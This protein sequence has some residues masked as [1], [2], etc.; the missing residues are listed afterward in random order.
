[1]RPLVLA[2]ALIALASVTYST[3]QNASQC[4]HLVYQ[5]LYLQQC[6][7]IHNVDGHHTKLLDPDSF[8]ALFLKDAVLPQLQNDPRTESVEVTRSQRS[9]L[10]T[11]GSATQTAGTE[12]ATSS[13][14]PLAATTDTP[15][16]AQESK[17]GK[18][19]SFEEWKRQ[20]V[21]QEGEDTNRRRKLTPPVRKSVSHQRQ[22]IDSI[23][24]AFGDDVGSMFDNSEDTPQQN[25]FHQ[26]Y[27]L[28][29]ATNQDPADLD[30]RPLKQSYLSSAPWNQQK[31]KQS[32]PPPPP[33][34][35]SPPPPSQQRQQNTPP[36]TDVPPRKTSAKSEK[37]SINPLKKLKELYN[38]AS[39]DCAATVLQANKGAKNPQAILY[40]S[41]DQYML[42][43]CSS[44]KF[45]IV[46]LCE[47]ILI[48]KFVLANYEFFSS[49]FKDFRVY[50]ADRYPPKEW[51]LLGQ[52]QARNTRD[53]QIFKVE[54]G[55]DWYQYIK[56]EFLSHYGNEYYCP[57]SLLRVHG[58][59]MMEYWTLYE[60]PK[61]T[62]EDEEEDDLLKGISPDP[63]VDET[64]FL[65]PAFS[66]VDIAT[67]L[68]TPSIPTV[69]DMLIAEREAKSVKLDNLVEHT[70]QHPESSSSLAPNES[71]DQS[72]LHNVVE[73]A[74][75]ATENPLQNNTTFNNN[76]ANVDESHLNLQTNSTDQDISLDTEPDPSKL[77]SS[78]N[79][80]SS[81]DGIEVDIS[82]PSPASS[83]Y[84]NVPD[85][86]SNDAKS[87]EERPNSQHHTISE[88]TSPSPT[89]EA[90]TV[91]VASDFNAQSTATTTKAP[92]GY[93]QGA[94][95]ES[96]YKTI[97]TRILNLEQNATLSQRYLDDQ[98]RML[99][100]VF[101][102]MEQRHHEQL[103]QLVGQLNSTASL[104]I[105]TMKRRY[106]RLYRMTARELEMTK[107]ETSKELQE[108]TAKLHIMADQ[109]VFEKRLSLIQ[110]ILLVSLFL[111]TAANKGTLSTLSPIVAAQAEERQ[112]RQSISH[113]QSSASQTDNA[114]ERPKLYHQPSKQVLKISKSSET[115]TPSK[116]SEIPEI[117]EAK[118]ELQITKSHME[119]IK[120]K[121]TRQS[122]AELLSKTAE[123]DPLRHERWDI[124][125]G[126]NNQRKADAPQIELKSDPYSEELKKTDVLPDHL[127]T[128]FLTDSPTMLSDV[129]PSPAL[130]H[131]VHSPAP[132]IDH[133]QLDGD[134]RLS[135]ASS[136]VDHL[137]LAYIHSPK[138]HSLRRERRKESST[139]DDDHPMVE[140]IQHIDNPPCSIDDQS[141]SQSPSDA[142]SVD[143]SLHNHE[144]DEAIVPTIDGK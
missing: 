24:G 41:K 38:Y 88:H 103:L 8:D 98:N 143:S 138:A 74:G 123:F 16:T 61:I 142:P 11:T 25:M 33:P 12:S 119:K 111:F 113:H 116:V 32:P 23:D 89:E 19:L 70:S 64:D 18:L 57:L 107:N 55:L 108:L 72:Q 54:A 100:E 48:D 135:R 110:L 128:P 35:P 10:Q 3:S 141:S 71:S 46:D 140:P 66:P 4:H 106:E 78:S 82:S 104:R 76:K 130:Q 122:T 131:G 132:A 85:A 7:P 114:V 30:N 21:L 50:V 49:T 26:Q 83:L 42:N 79:H 47:S 105:D 43:K 124:D 73:A 139:P 93:G 2:S 15:P 5:P 133:L 20:V 22:Q 99:N 40:E 91:P 58:N 125:H 77:V 39:I 137:D 126:T 75:T 101:E 136:F 86:K 68:I 9:P 94:N 59:P 60:K 45:V 63:V 29:I 90:N 112:R 84:S 117:S 14:R 1:M 92:F 144:I 96:I 127:N 62:G 56:I 67:E 95:M 81:S 118:R 80:R 109:V 37:E 36:F 87:E 44:D 17:S 13:S 52:W 28:P 51:R 34:P 120:L 53:L 69:E 6:P 27:P 97:M 115:S 102:T 31:Q 129:W 65:W 134:L 121:P